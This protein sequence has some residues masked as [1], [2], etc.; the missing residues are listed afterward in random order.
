MTL[1]LNLASH[2]YVNRRGLYAFYG[3]STGLLLLLLVFNISSVWRLRQHRLQVQ[4][5]LAELERKLGRERPADAAE[6]SPAEMERERQEVAFANEILARDGFRWTALLNRLEGVAIDG[7]S[8]RSLQP[9]FKENSL[10]L[11]GVAAGLQQMRK[12]IDRLLAAPAFSEVYLLS[13]DTT[14]VKDN[15]GSEHQAIAFSLVL[16]GVF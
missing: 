13:Q 16:K 5:H 9:N 6:A 2:T 7:I 8:I 1:Q 15:L 12:F 11:S 10:K 14:T 4:S 3:I